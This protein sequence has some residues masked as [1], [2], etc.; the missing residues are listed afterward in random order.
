MIFWISFWLIFIPMSLIF[1]TKVINKKNFPKRK[2]QNVIVCCNHMSNLDAP[3]LDL[4]FKRK[5]YYLCK[6]ELFKNKFSGFFMKAYGGISVDRSKADLGAIKRTLKL[7]NDGKTLGVFPQ[8]HRQEEGDIDVDTVK[9]G[10]S[11]FSLRTGVP[12]LPM[13]ILRRPKA[14][15]KNYIIVGEPIFPDNERTK[16]KT[17][18]EE[19]TRIIVDKMNELLH[20]GKERFLK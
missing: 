10:V 13:V 18:A 16:D 17:Y 20:N 6:K 11:L 9:N 2:K 19:F 7:L 12:V 1:P 8:G 5:I 4:R 15:K 14:F 3:I